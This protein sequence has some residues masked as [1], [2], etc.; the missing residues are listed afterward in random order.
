M[1]KTI[2]MVKKP[3]EL[4]QELTR[5]NDIIHDCSFDKKEIELDRESATLK[6]EFEVEEFDESREFKKIFKKY[7]LTIFGVRDFEIVAD[8]EEGPGSTDMFYVMEYDAGDNR[9]ILELEFAEAIDVFVDNV[10]IMIEDTGEV[11]REREKYR[12]SD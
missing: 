5:I 9:L 2:I 4:P 12:I 11:I 8:T 7:I 3:E 6:I 1:N 10:G